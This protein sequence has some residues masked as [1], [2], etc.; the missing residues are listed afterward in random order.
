MRAICVCTRGYACSTAH[1]S[2]Q[3]A[4]ERWVPDHE[5]KTRLNNEMLMPALVQVYGER[6][7]TSR[8]KSRAE[9]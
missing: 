5:L 3:A 8:S 2:A 4:L 9:R 7:H 1:V 6:D